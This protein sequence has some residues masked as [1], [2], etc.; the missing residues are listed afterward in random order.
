MTFNSAKN[1]KEK[2]P[3]FLPMGGPNGA[4]GGMPI[5]GGGGML[6]GSGARWA[7]PGGAGGGGT[8]PGGPGGG[9]GI[10]GIPMGHKQSAFNFLLFI[11]YL[12]QNHF[13]EMS[14][15]HKIKLKTEGYD[16]WLWQIKITQ[17]LIKGSCSI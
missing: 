1:K 7:E 8:I 3:Q 11:F 12:W 5:G 14:N 2:V 10:W 9:M 17:I 4:L 6:G 16:C 13:R 15:I